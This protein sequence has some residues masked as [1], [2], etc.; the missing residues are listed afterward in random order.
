M[1]YGQRLTLACNIVDEANALYDRLCKIQRNMLRSA[2]HWQANVARPL[3]IELAISAA[4]TAKR[5]AEET[6]W[7]VDAI[8]A[9][10]FITKYAAARRLIHC[11]KLSW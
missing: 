5:A 9:G 8:G 7:Y 4:Y 2:S 1:N 6:T 3:K 11:A 10:K